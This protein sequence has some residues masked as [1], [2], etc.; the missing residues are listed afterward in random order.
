MLTG[1][2]TD[3]PVFSEVTFRTNGSYE[4]TGMILHD[5]HKASFHNSGIYKFINEGSMLLFVTMEG[6]QIIYTLEN[7]KQ[8]SFSASNPNSIE[9][10]NFIKLA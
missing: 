3:N 7:I 4:L 10:Y 2:S 1:Y 5:G 9:Y 8:S 6:E